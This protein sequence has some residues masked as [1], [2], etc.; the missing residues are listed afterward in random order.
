VHEKEDEVLFVHSGSGVGA[1]GDERRA[2]AAGATLY[3]PQGTW[4]GIESR[5]DELAILWVVSPPHFADALRARALARDGK[6]SSAELNAI[7]RQQ[8]YRDGGD[9]F[10][11][12]LEMIAAALAL[13][14]AIAM[15]WSGAHPVRAIATY[16]GSATLATTLTMRAVAPGYLP[17]VSFAIVSVAI[18]AAASVGALGGVG[19]LRLM[20]R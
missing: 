16:A 9:F 5:S 11:P 12:R 14:G 7:T 8:G 17:P 15:L 10:L 20:R 18:L 2:V 3:I 19:I 4:H 6:I 1:V 13:G